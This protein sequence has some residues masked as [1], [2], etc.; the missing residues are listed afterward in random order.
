MTKTTTHSK[1]KKQLV[2]ELRF[3]EFDI[4][5][6]KMKLIEVSD[7]IQDGTHFSPQLV[8]DGNYKYI[9]SKN[10]R[11]GYMEL[12]DIAYVSDEAHSDI[13]K[14]CNVQ[15]NDILLTKDGSAT[16][17]VCLNTLDEEFSLLSSVAFIRANKSFATNE[18]IYQCISGP[19]G[20]R[21]ILASIAGQA[22]TRITLTKLRNFKFSY[23]S[24]P[25][26]KKIASFLSAI[27]QKIQQLT[28][29]KTLLEQ[30]KKGVMQQL[31]SG[32]LRF[33]DEDEG[34]Y[35]E[36]EE[37]MLGD[38]GKIKMCK[39]IFSHQTSE[40]GEIPFYKIGTFGKVADAFIPKE[41]FLEFKEK[42]SYPKTGEIL[43]SASGT[44]GRTV[45][46]DGSESYFQDSNI[47]WIENNEKL[48]TN[49]FLFYVYQ[50][51]RYESEGGTI[52][53]L[54]NSIISSAKFL[55]PT[56]IEEQS[57]VTYLL[58]NIDTK[59]ENTSNQ[60]TQT[61]TFKRG[62]LQKMFV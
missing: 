33:K 12:S 10:I 38:V 26:Q 51:V 27:D 50:I 30:Y 6:E 49:A 54:Y 5:W 36:W 7:K 57:K 14:R 59:I 45:I 25:E 35:P 13:Y 16:G 24:L 53:R 48:I 32:E 42:Y 55:M 60:I 46:Y 19:M 61:Q 3:K 58:S 43:M 8:E 39:R 28:K 1:T 37:K 17:T 9:T 41:L 2:P 52:Q 21:E 22:I 4:E 18:F 15:L 44:L 29:K 56:D 40:I 11:N 20:Q 47:V 34:D 62:L 23:P 31:F